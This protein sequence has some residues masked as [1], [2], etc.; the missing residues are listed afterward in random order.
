MEIATQP[1]LYEPSL[2]NDNYVDKM[3][4]QTILS[5]GVRCPCNP[6]GTI[7]TNRT[8]M[9]SHFKTHCHQSWIETQNKNKQNHLTELFE[10]REL[11]KQQT[12]LIAERDQKI[13]RLERDVREKEIAI[14]ALSSILH[15]NIKPP[16]GSE[17]LGILD[18]DN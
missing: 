18:I 10:L 14:R 2:D 5:K 11:S 12:L 7:F 13:I 16:M 3:P 1:I 9:T 8:N 15:T 17:D 6:R 4:N